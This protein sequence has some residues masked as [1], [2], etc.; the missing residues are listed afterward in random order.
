MEKIQI[1]A[2]AK[3]N[4]Y[5]HVVGKRQDGYHL[6]DSL[7]VFTE[8]GDVISVEESDSFSLEVINS[9]NKNNITKDETF[10][11]NGPDNIVYKAAFALANKLNVECKAKIVLEKKLPLA[12][13]IGG[14]STDAGATLIALQKLWKK[15]LEKEE[16]MKLALELGADV[17]SCIEKKPV[18]VSGIGEVLEVAKKIPNMSILLVNP[19][20][21][22][23]TPLV[24]KT[25]KPVFSKP[26]PLTMAYSS[27]FEF[28]NQLKLRHNDLENAACELEPSVREVLNYFDKTENCL[29]RAMSG[30]GG[31]CFGIYKDIETAN[32][33]KERVCKA[34]PHW[35]VEATNILQ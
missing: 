8:F 20:K 34:H 21:P 2:P 14:G 11:S 19:N 27:V 30:S 13:G 33:A 4:L 29:F 10:L 31:T 24:F 32:L 26:M 16:L 35:W 1:T 3:V 6:L 28:V 17:P 9:I 15:E 7:F 18:Q 5:L 12:S 22:V 25:R 23:S